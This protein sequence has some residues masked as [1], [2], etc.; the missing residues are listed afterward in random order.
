MQGFHPSANTM[1]L[2]PLTMTAKP[3][4]ANMKYLNYPATGVLQPAAQPHLCG[5]FQY[6]G[7]LRQQCRP[8]K[9]A[10]WQAGLVRC[11]QYQ[12]MPH[13]ALFRW[14]G[15]LQQEAAQ[16]AAVRRRRGAVTPTGQRRPGAEL[17]FRNRRPGS[18]GK[19]S[20]VLA[21]QDAGAA[22]LDEGPFAAAAAGAA[23]RGRCRLAPGGRPL[24]GASPLA[25]GCGFPTA[26]TV[27]LLLL[28]LRK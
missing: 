9:R 15:L 17:L 25:L 1:L 26:T 8:C 3:S 7:R 19:G 14:E 6:R 16:L 27:R 2:G 23:G 13:W 11:Q 22:A 18:D 5:S 24:G 28:V 20:T 12:C 10:C 4:M 21:G